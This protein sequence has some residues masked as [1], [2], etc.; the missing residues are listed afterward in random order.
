MTTHDHTLA[1]VQGFYD[2]AMDET[3]WPAVLRDL[4]ALT[5]SQAARTRTDLYPINWKT[6]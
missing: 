6:G 5:N 1:T 3:L 4:V 2:A